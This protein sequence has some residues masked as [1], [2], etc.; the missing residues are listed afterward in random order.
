MD[1]GAK[2]PR[3]SPEIEETRANNENSKKDDSKN[4][5]KPT[6][7]FGRTGGAYI[8][9]ARLRQMQAQITDN[10]LKLISEL[11]GKH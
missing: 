6:N 2:R 9:P 1:R 10:R 3:Y 4:A 7:I 11:H 5:D 8:P